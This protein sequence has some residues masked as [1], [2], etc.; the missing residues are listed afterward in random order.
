MRARS[1]ATWRFAPCSRTGSSATRSPASA[2]RPPEWTCARRVRGLAYRASPT[3]RTVSNSACACCAGRPRSM[4]SAARRGLV[5]DLTRVRIVDLARR[6]GLFFAAVG[7]RLHR[8][9][10]C[11][12]GPGGDAPAFGWSSRAAVSRSRDR[13]ARRQPPPAWRPRR[14]GLQRLDRP[15][16][17]S[18]LGVEA[19]RALAGD[20]DR[21]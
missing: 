15:R 19:L 16:S 6:A 20:T 9:Q 7:L 13:P 8:R 3:A 14:P 5:E 11:A 2:A 17:V 12:F 4:F 21:G 1:D 10:V 18:L